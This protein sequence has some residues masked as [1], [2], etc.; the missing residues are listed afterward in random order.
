MKIL[1]LSVASLENIRP[2]D[3]IRLVTCRLPTTKTNPFQSLIK[4]TKQ[5]EESGQDCAV[6]CNFFR[7]RISCTPSSNYYADRGCV[8]PNASMSVLFKASFAAS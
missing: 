7:M 1:Y 3:T 2:D 5:W 6:V 8:Y 4:D